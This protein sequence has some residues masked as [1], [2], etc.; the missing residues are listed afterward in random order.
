MVTS[1]DR[2]LCTRRR[3][4]CG[5]SIACGIALL[6][7][8]TARA[9]EGDEDDQ[10]DE[11]A[12]TRQQERA[13]DAEMPV[14][15]PQL[16]LTQSASRWGEKLTAARFELSQDVQLDASLPEAPEGTPMANLDLNPEVWAQKLGRRMRPT[17]R[18]VAMFTAA[19]FMD[20]VVMN[21]NDRAADDRIHRLCGRYK[22]GAYT[23]AWRVQ[24]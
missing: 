15:L 10:P 19:F 8:G 21:R 3:R 23:L 4:L 14:D 18:Q 1:L 17:T 12:V 13:S 2:K 24:F 9:E 16:D 5:W 20:G 22:R 11:H 6:A 7:C